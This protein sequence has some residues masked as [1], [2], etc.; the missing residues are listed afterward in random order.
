MPPTKRAPN[1]PGTAYQGVAGNGGSDQL[2]SKLRQYQSLTQTAALVDRSEVGRLRVSG[3]DAL[4]L[5]NR[6]STNKIDDLTS[7]H[8]MGTVLTT[9]KGRVIDLLFITSLDDYL[10]V[11]TSP[12]RQQKV[13]DWIDFYNFGEDVQVKDI[14][15]ETRMLG[16]VGP[17]APAAIQLAL[18][19]DVAKM[20]RFDS[21]AAGDRIIVKTDFP[22][23]VAF[24]I[25]VEHSLAD[26]VTGLFERGGVSVADH[27]VAEFVRVENRVPGP[28]GELTE[29]YNPLE[30]SLLPYV[31]FNKDCYIGQEVVARL[32]TYDK[33]QRHLV[34]LEWDTQAILEPGAALM[35][36][37][38]KVGT[39]TSIAAAA[40]TVERSALA[41]VRKSHVQPG[42][43]LDADT[44]GGQLTVFVKGLADEK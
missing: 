30:A 20:D 18:E 35:A 22:G 37:D 23:C 16:I 29:D 32:N 13:I 41:Y 24:D 44:G 36:D 14:T 26:D 27:D 5:L 15:K 40:W 8:G 3:G 4:D 11:L 17:E 42:T 6:L 12:G 33:V 2:S 38:K 9:N 31:N 25:V 28:D 1:P 34:A 43:R 39:V 7:G 10:L 21:M 19:A